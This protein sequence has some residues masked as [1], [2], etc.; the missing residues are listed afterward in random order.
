MNEKIRILIE[1]K[2]S[3]SETVHLFSLIRK[4]LE[5]LSKSEMNK[6]YSNLK[7]F[8]D[9]ILHAKI[10]VS[11]AG[12]KMILEIHKTINLFKK[13]HT[14]KVIKEVSRVL[15]VPFKEQLKQ[16]L[17]K[18][19]LFANII[20]NHQKWIHF[21]QSLFSVLESTEVILKLKLEP[22]LE[23]DPLKQGMWVKKISVIKSNLGNSMDKEIFCLKITTSDTTKI[24][25]P[26]TSAII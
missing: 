11:P 1:K 24:V 19:K 13:Q 16:F 25:I 22:D 23:R 26:L 21:L 2:L 6:K 8:C 18:R 5:L 12:S 7:L 17:E 20:E 4:E 9:W 15:L 10:D 14:D 3:D